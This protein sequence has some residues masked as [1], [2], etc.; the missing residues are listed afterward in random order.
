M[1]MQEIQALLGRPKEIVEEPRKA[2]GI[3]ANFQIWHY[4][5]RVAAINA[6]VTK[7]VFSKDW[8]GKPSE[9][10]LYPSLGA[11]KY[12]SESLE[13]V[14]RFSERFLKSDLEIGSPKVTYDRHIAPYRAAFVCEFTILNLGKSPLGRVDLMVSFVDSADAPFSEAKATRIVLGESLPGVVY[15]KRDRIY[16]DALSN[17]VINVPGFVRFAAYTSDGKLLSVGNSTYKVLPK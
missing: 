5:R 4:C 3:N 6:E 14:R 17:R 15:A 16:S 2:G 11:V 13:P 9:W 10:A 12:E 8:F 1:T 7:L